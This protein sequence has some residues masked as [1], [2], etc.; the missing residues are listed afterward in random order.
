MYYDSTPQST[1]DYRVQVHI[2][3]TQ[4]CHHGVSVSSRGGGGGG[5]D[6]VTHNQS[7]SC[8][9]AKITSWKIIRARANELHALVQV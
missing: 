9:G 3:Y 7:D 2:I 8:N 6:Q 1:E 5:E 4:P